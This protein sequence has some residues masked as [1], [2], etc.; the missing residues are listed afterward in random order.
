MQVNLW[1]LILLLGLLKLLIMALLLWMPFRS[2]SA[3]DV[4]Q[5]S[6]FP[7][8]D[9][10]S[11]TLPAGPLNP[12]PHTPLRGPSLRRGPHGSPAPASP[13]RVRRHP[14]R[15]AQRLRLR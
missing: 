10:G 9:G 11:R 6:D 5:T 8:E 2:D 14:A 15:V 12:H 1:M 13:E 7:D 3:M 4:P